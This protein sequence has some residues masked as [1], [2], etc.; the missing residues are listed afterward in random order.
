MK[1]YGCQQELKSPLLRTDKIIQGTPCIKIIE[2]T[3]VNFCYYQD[4]IVKE[5]KSR[6]IK[7]SSGHRFIDDIFMKRSWDA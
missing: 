4:E 7:K 1:D 5:D 6:L 3:K 2:A